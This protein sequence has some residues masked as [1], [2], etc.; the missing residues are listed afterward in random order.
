MPFTSPAQASLD[1]I[2]ESMERQCRLSRDY[3]AALKT[4]DREAIA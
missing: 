4:R 2:N 1:A 3:A